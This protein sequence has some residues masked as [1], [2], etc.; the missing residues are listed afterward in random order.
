MNI[1]IFSHYFTPEIGAPSAR[2][3]DMA[4]HWIAMGHEVQVITGF[5][6]HPTGHIYP[7]HRAGRYAVDIID[8]ITVHRNWTY[9]TPNRGFIKKS[10]GHITL[11]VSSRI[12]SLPRMKRPDVVI[13]TSPTFFA[14]MSAAAAAKR[15]R[16]P[17]VMEVR[18]LWPA[19][20]VDLGVIRNPNVI[21]LLEMWELSLYRKANHIVTV[22][23]AF[24][25]DL[26]RRSVP[27]TKVTTILN[28]AD[29]EF[30][31]PQE[32]TGVLDLAAG[33]SSG[34]NVLYIGAHGIS[35]ALSCILEA[36]REFKATDSVRFFFVGEG[37]EKAYLQS[38][39]TQMGLLNVHFLD[40]VDKEG[41]RACYADADIC[42]VPLRNIPI[43]K[44][45]IPS[46]MF[47]IL[48]MGRPII[49]SLNGEAADI[50]EASRGA[51]I[52]PPEKPRLIAS[53]IRQILER[54]SL[55]ASLSYHGR[56]FVVDKYSRRALA[57]RYIEVLE[58]VQDGNN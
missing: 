8:G 12:L 5:P 6:N 46:K 19:C 11:W 32:P 43:F 20:F 1:A 41:V 25:D 36:A 14:A 34:F 16:V 4:R 37:A 15:F 56:A 42:L 7:G 23:S 57:A 3:H 55:A 48:A 47:E 18:D 30:W 45:F 28:G 53:A 9:I 27:I 49:A 22:T 29:E 58:T 13:G 44:G 21:R 24:K 17:F 51:L 52:V 2:I 31:V 38:F 33:G 26:V 10:V 39:A 50:L 35:Q 54:P 40:P